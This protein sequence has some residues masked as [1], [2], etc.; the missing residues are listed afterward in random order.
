MTREEYLNQ[1]QA[2]RQVCVRNILQ[3]ANENTNRKRLFEK[4]SRRLQMGSTITVVGSG[5]KAIRT[6]LIAVAKSL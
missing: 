5:R 3:V 6:Y 4:N 1:M 2:K